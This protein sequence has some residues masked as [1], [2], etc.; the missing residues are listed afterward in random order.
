MNNRIKKKVS[1]R[2]KFWYNSD[3]PCLVV[4]TTYRDRKL[5]RKKDH[6]YTIKHRRTYGGLIGCSYEDMLRCLR[7]CT[8]SV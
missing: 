5:M 7:R 2:K 8:R 1:K 6:D 3:L 4:T